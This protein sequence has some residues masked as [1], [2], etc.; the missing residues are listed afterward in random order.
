MM[1]SARAAGSWSDCNHSPTHMASTEIPT[2]TS[3]SHQQFVDLPEEERKLLQRLFKKLGTYPPRVLAQTLAQINYLGLIKL[4]NNGYG[5]EVCHI[6]DILRTH[7]GFLNVDLSENKIPVSGAESISKALMENKVLEVIKLDRN[8]FG[9]EGIEHIANA[10][11]VNKTLRSISV[12]DCKFTV[13]GIKL[14]CDALKENKSLVSIHMSGNIMGD[15]GA[16]LLATC[17]QVNRSLKYVSCDDCMI[18]D[19]GA[20]ALYQIMQRNQGVIV[21]CTRFNQILDSALI[22][23]I[24]AL[25][26]KRRE[27]FLKHDKE[28]RKLTMANQR[29]QQKKLD[30]M[31][32]QVAAKMKKV[33]QKEKDLETQKTKVEEAASQVKLSRTTSGG[34]SLMSRFSK[35][36]ASNEVWCMLVGSSGSGEDELLQAFKTLVPHAQIGDGMEGKYVSADVY[37]TKHPVHLSLHHYSSGTKNSRARHLGYMSSDIVVFMFSLNDRMSFDDIE[38]DFT[39]DALYANTMKEKESTFYIVG[40][41]ADLRSNPPSSDDVPSDKPKLLANKIKAKGY[42]EIGTSNQSVEFKKLLEL[43]QKDA[44]KV[45]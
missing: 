30:E 5:E 26:K 41:N 13:K 4:D 38:E 6:A 12:M 32:H 10:L 33:E 23:K 40:Y 31:E 43:I 17:L 1:A 45:K 36:K 8:D 22:G 2:D 28:R 14:L 20:L 3:A 19:V 29:Q 16:T 34:A 35:K 25:V 39:A 18:S 24:D 9:D 37:V 7:K 42:F 11:K 21:T 15:D 27:D 44:A